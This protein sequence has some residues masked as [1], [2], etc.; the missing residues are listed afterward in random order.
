MPS[1]EQE[2]VDYRPMASEIG[3]F[4]RVFSQFTL[5]PWRIR[6]SPIATLPFHPTLKM[7]V[8]QC[9]IAWH[10]DR[11]IYAR[12]STEWLGSYEQE[13]DGRREYLRATS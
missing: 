2:E 3:L 13:N 10:D 11:E 5:A 6:A 4:C 9:L 8:L 7:A 1:H 12:L